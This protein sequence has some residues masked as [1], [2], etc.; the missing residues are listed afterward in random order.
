MPSKLCRICKKVKPLTNFYAHSTVG[1]FA[2]CKRCVSDVNKKKRAE[3]LTIKS[4][5]KFKICNTC[6]KKKSISQ[7]TKGRGKC[8]NCYNTYCRNRRLILKANRIKISEKYCP[9][10]MR[11]KPIFEFRR[12]DLLIDGYSSK[13]RV[14]IDNI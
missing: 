6:L 1:H 7:F 13:C 12:R 4:K 9:E 8:K 5:A 11:G 14:C 3:K 10:C 2:N